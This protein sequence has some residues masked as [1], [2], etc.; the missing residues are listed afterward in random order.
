MNLVE[1]VVGEVYVADDVKIVCVGESSLM[2][3]CGYEQTMLIEDAYL[4]DCLDAAII[5]NERVVQHFSAS[6]PLVD[7]GEYYMTV[8]DYIETEWNRGCMNFECLL[9]NNEWLRSCIVDESS[10]EKLPIWDWHIGYSDGR[11]SV[12]I[13]DVRNTYAELFNNGNLIQDMVT[14]L[15]SSNR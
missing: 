13:G 14:K 1:G 3:S 2:L 4:F 10:R 9:T 5:V 15:F 8:S 6:Q 11:T 7:C 12:S